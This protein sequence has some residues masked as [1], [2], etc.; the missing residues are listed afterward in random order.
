MA[1]AGH[2][3]VEAAER[4][5]QAL[6]KNAKSRSDF[7]GLESDPIPPIGSFDRRSIRLA[8]LLHDV[9]HGPF[10]HA[11]ESLIIGRAPK[12]FKRVESVL[13]KEFS[14]T[15]GI[16]GS[17]LMSMLLVLSNPMKKVL[18]HRYF[19]AVEQKHRL[20]PAIAAHIIGSRDCLKATSPRLYAT[21]PSAGWRE[22]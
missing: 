14:G 4:M 21:S 2:R 11:S 22:F 15:S 12:A 5:L 1:A 20:A 3:V 19:R 6:E 9:G 7:A 17:E 16:S 8:A 18:E 13:R 10:S